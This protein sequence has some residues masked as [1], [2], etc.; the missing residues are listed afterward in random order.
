VQEVLDSVDA[1]AAQAFEL[2]KSATT[3]AKGV[4]TL[5]LEPLDLSEQM[6]TLEPVLRNL[7]VKVEF[8]LSILSEGRPVIADSLQME[9]I[10]MNLVANARQAIA[11]DGLVEVIV[12]ED[13]G[14]TVDAPPVMTLTVR[15]TGCGMTPD[16]QHRMFEPYFT[17]RSASGGTGLG[18]A[19]VHR[20]VTLQGGQLTVVSDVGQGTSVTVSVPFADRGLVE[21]P[22]GSGD[23]P[24]VRVS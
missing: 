10:I 22:D 8:R 20:L 11:G 7:L 18:L 24:A 9:R 23:R 1:S 6:R 3:L 2:V 15:D 14:E 5:H 13:V 17:T 12:R 21:S 4:A 19:T 16:V